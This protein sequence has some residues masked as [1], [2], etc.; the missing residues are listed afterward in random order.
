M[1]ACFGGA[2]ARGR[3][4]CGNG[5]HGGVAGACVQ[6]CLYHVART[7]G[8][9]SCQLAREVGPDYRRLMA[10]GLPRREILARAHA[11]TH[12]NAVCGWIPLPGST[13]AQA[14][15]PA[16]IAPPLPAW[17]FRPPSH[18]QP[19]SACFPTPH[20]TLA[21][22]RLGSARQVP[23]PSTGA[24][25][26]QVLRGGAGRG[27]GGARAPA[28]S[29]PWCKNVVTRAAVLC[30]ESPCPCHRLWLL[31]S[32]H[33]HPAGHGRTTITSAGA[34]PDGAVVCV[35]ACVRAHVAGGGPG[36][37]LR[38]APNFRQPPARHS[39]VHCPPPSPASP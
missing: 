2:H 35:C 23:T 31:T 38:A 32:R 24:Y 13:C 30:C 39:P 26:G 15:L 37:R 22:P 9:G 3:A 8:P 7:I 18:A 10:S 36:P 17:A 25:R 12:M 34:M 16:A 19:S 21:L 27:R 4:G 14:Y 11:C 33:R 28:P 20:L 5:R 29:P 1:R 6:A